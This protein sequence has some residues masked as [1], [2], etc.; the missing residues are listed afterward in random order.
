[1]S[2]AMMDESNELLREF[3]IES[4]ENL[5]RLDRELLTLEK[6]PTHLESLKGI[7]RTIH[8]VKGTCGFLGLGKLESV[9]HVG[10]N[11]LS[12]LRDGELLVDQAIMTALLQL[13]DA[14]REMLANIE[15]SGNEGDKDYSALSTL[16]T[17]LHDG[18][19]QEGG[20]L[21][22]PAPP[23]GAQ[24]RAPDP[25]P[26]AVVAMAPAAPP[27][28][29]KPTAPPAVAAATPAPAAAHVPP[30]VAAAP[31]ETTK[32]P[33]EAHGHGVA[34]A[35]VRVDV[36]LL[37]RLMNLV[38]ELVLARNQILQLV[39]VI[40]EQ[41]FAAGCQRLDHITTELQTSI[42][43]TRMQPIG[44]VWDKLP[45][46][47]R[48][49]AI[50]CKKQ[51]RV[52]MEGRETELDKTIIEAIRGPLTHL[53]RNSLDHGIETP[54]ERRA[55]G[56]SEEGT[57]S[58]RAFH[59]GGQVNI[60]ISDDGAGLNLKRIAEKALERG[61]M[62]PEQLSRLGEGELANLI[63]LPGFSTAKQVSNISGR[64]VGMDVVK[65]SI[66]KLGGVVDL[67][68]RPGNGTTIHIKIP[69]TLAIVP[70][71]IVSSGSDRYAIPQ[72]SLLELLR[73]E[74]DQVATRIE[75][76]HGTPVYRL[77][78]AL[79]P[80][81]DLQAQ[82]H[83]SSAAR[84]P[85]GA[86]HIVVL[87]ADQRRFGLI[88]DRINDTEEIVVKPL[89]H[90]LK[91]LNVF[92]GATIM[93]D[94]DVAL[95][96]DIPALAHRVGLRTMADRVTA[97]KEST[98]SVE[99]GRQSLLLFETGGGRAAIPLS[100]VARLEKFKRSQIETAGTRQVVQ[101]FDD[102]LPV[103]DVSAILG[104]QSAPEEA[105][106]PVVVFRDK[107]RSAGLTVGRIVDIV[108]VQLE[109]KA[110]GRPAA[111]GVVGWAVVQDKVTELLDL[112]EL[113]EGASADLWADTAAALA[114]AFRQDAV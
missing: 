66:E 11:L 111:P 86:V 74:G 81:V 92:A 56:K 68:T 38:G 42:M 101:Y 7:F 96:L 13:V 100:M 52:T 112:R 113:L 91:G 73:I 35:Y 30:P 80:L 102:L 2:V 75:T 10:E 69:L 49:L 65:T 36:H 95:I 59:E 27:A 63:F 3:L 53:V 48:D 18:A 90:L 34:D 23:A 82:L 40:K 47:V 97:R 14:I 105:E 85:G 50:A 104:R 9:S 108:D 93:G 6:N 89:G 26:A 57:L 33:E 83:G 67:L 39:P 22:A 60:E 12:R 103:V 44:N 19:S 106:V 71:L 72:A 5:D 109:V 70:A 41:A 4:H 28:S 31:P 98:A 32:A 64:G 88:V 87:Q 20:L 114:G 84:K 110:M 25:T 37:D 54:A 77:R 78:G 46:V 55:S 76:I 45:R 21:A 17:Q 79:L 15:A 24:S 43:Q 1:M 99:S 61:L 51:V 107:G 16:L 58:L 8:T 94:G 62:S 29:T